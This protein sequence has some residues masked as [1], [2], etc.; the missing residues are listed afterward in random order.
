MS[1]TNYPGYTSS[2]GY[3]NS[4]KYEPKQYVTGATPGCCELGCR[5]TELEAML[6]STL[7]ITQELLVKREKE[8]QMDPTRS[9][10]CEQGGHSFSEKDPDMQVLSITGKDKDGKQVT[11][12]RTI[13]GPC[14]VQTKTTLGGARNAPAPELPPAAEA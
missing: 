11:E 3:T 12:S 6:A 14:A 10:W 5:A 8:A 1:Y 13:C 4:A 7:N 9:L 2:T